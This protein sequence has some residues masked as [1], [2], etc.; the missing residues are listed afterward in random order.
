MKNFV[1]GLTSQELPIMGYQFGSSGPPVLILGG[2]HGN[3][4]EG[5][6]AACGVLRRFS[7]SFT[8]RLQVCL[9]PMFNLDGVLVSTRKN[10]RQVDL[11]RNM[12]TND[13]SA[14]VTEDK[15]HPG[16]GA[17]SEP[18]T[19]ALIDYLDRVRPKLI[20]SFHSWHPM[21]NIN[22]RCEKEAEIIAK[23]T[24]YAITDNIGYPTPGCLG[25][26]C[27]VERDMPTITYEIERGLSVQQTLSVH[28][29]A[30][31]EALKVT[32]ERG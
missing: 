12:P 3:E 32:E 11:N 20:V 5:V 16:T 13:W 7:E 8:F 4:P 26:Y 1:F 18:E 24:G 19:Q 9:V 21:V 30:L 29:K 17:A 6:I 22:G 10:A 25:T 28:V 31:L 23:Y 2:V 15:Y 14:V 27:G